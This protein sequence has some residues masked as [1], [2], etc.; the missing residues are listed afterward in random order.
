[1]SDS[2]VGAREHISLC[3]T[4]DRVLNKGVVIHGDL[5]ISVADVDLIYLGL[6]FL[7]ASIESAHD[8]GILRF[9][10]RNQAQRHIEMHRTGT[11]GTNT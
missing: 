7:L 10:G 8:A 1:M 6:R 2:D 3:E 9:G 4:L 11:R 5:T